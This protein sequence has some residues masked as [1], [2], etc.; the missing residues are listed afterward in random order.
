MEEEIKC[1]IIQCPKCEMEFHSYD[2]D[3]EGIPEHICLNN[4]E[5][6]N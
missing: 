3:F 2:E 6:S 1:K 5:Y 4:K